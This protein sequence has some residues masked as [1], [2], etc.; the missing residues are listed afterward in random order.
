M[1]NGTGSGCWLFS[2]SPGWHRRARV[3]EIRGQQRAGGDLRAIRSLNA[4]SPHR[5]TLLFRDTCHNTA[6]HSP[7][8]RTCLNI[9]AILL[10]NMI[11]TTNICLMQVFERRWRLL[12]RRATSISDPA[13]IQSIH[14]SKDVAHNRCLRTGAPV[15]SNFCRQES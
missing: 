14:A 3:G 11:I 15:G 7:S 1:T 12:Q 10:C 6:L 8:T 2:V 5:M 9:A 13:T 4:A